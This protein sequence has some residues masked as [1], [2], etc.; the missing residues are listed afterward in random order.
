MVP[1]FPGSICHAGTYDRNRNNTI[2]TRGKRALAPQ[3]L[4]REPKDFQSFRGY[5]RVP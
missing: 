4:A 2:A 5:Y 1:N 3:E